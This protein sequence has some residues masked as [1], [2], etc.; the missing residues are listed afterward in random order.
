[1][2]AIAVGNTI[3][4][5]PSEQYPLITADLYQLLEASDVPAGTI[6][7]VTGH[8]HELLKTLAEHD[9]LDALWVFADAPTCA[10]AKSLSIGNLKQT[11]T[12]EAR[13]IDWFNPAQS[14]D[15]F[16]LQHATQTKNIW[17]PYGE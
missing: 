14:Q 13:Q 7:I 15:R 2:P 4:A 8:R 3:V 6:N 9:D 12:N 11:F 17:V 5:I 16:F 10:T 1:M